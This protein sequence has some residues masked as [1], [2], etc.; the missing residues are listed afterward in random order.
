V[1]GPRWIAPAAVALLLLGLA[2]PAS[3]VP[4][5]DASQ[6]DHPVKLIFIHH[7]TGENW[8]DDGHG[9]LGLAL[10]D[11]GYFVSDTNYGWGPGGIGD[12]T[13]IG[14]WWSWFRG[15]SSGTYMTALY[16]ESGQHSSYSRLASDPGGSNEI[17][18]FKSCFPNSALGGSAG[19]TPPAIGS[20]PLRGQDCY[21]GAHTVANA[22]G[23]YIDLLEYFRTRQDKLFVAVTAPPLSSGTYSTNARAFN[24]WLVRD[25]LDGYPYKN[26]CGIDLYNVLTT[27]G[28][29][30]GVNDLGAAD[31]NHHRVLSGA[32]QHKTDG[33]DDANPNVLEYASSPGD[34]HPSAAGGRKA[35]AEL[36]PLINVAYNAWQEWLGPEG[37]VSGLAAR[38]GDKQVALIWSNPAS[39]CASVRVLSSISGYATS[40]TDTAGQAVVWEGTATACQDTTLTNGRRYYYSVYVQHGDASWSD[41]AHAEAIPKGLARVSVPA[42]STY[43]PLRNRPFYISGTI[44]PVHVGGVGVGRVYLYRRVGS[45]YYFYRYVPVRTPLNG[46]RYVLRY[47]LPTPGYW[48][49]RAYHADGAHAASISGYR[50][51]RVR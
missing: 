22:K 25:W 39:D 51:F 33:D 35:S 10:R 11:D 46:A 49:M 4:R 44:L 6:P 37:G 5:L 45:T 2:S 16:A 32:I 41:A 48:R 23:I 29:S 50:Y 24:D 40:P 17:V 18:M 38:A 43:A 19:G 30:A 12:T 21:N 8:L 42:M 1:R 3:A 34:D 26:V 27:N 13:D 36:V 15:P 47:R 7:S 28:G 20:N 14:H 31:G 9:R